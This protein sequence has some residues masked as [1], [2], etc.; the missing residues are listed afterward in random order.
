LRLTTKDDFIAYQK[1]MNKKKISSEKNI[2]TLIHKIAAYVQAKT[3]RSIES[4]NVAL[5]AQIELVPIR[6]KTGT[7][8]RNVN[9]YEELDSS[10]IFNKLGIKFVKDSTLFKIRIKNQSNT[11]LFFSVINIDANNEISVLFPN[12]KYT[13]QEFRLSA[14]ETKTINSSVF[15]ART[16]SGDDMLKL[17]V[18]PS[19]L[20]IRRIIN[21][22]GAKEEKGSGS[23]FERL[24]QATY[25]SEVQTRSAEQLN[26]EI[27]EIG[28]YSLMYRVIAEQAN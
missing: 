16:S 6:K 22:R 12:D 18:T 17:I 28:I 24:V 13:P 3:L 20:E 2:D 19:P 21:A 15:M 1:R 9:D 11:T 27:E 7:T 14:M 25:P 4:E 26:M 23:A 10:F 8:G 5:K